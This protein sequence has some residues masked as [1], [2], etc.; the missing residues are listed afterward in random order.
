MN[1]KIYL[2]RDEIQFEL[3]PY[4]NDGN[5]Y[6]RQSAHIWECEAIKFIEKDGYEADV[7]ADYGHDHHKFRIWVCSTETNESDD[8]I[9]LTE[10]EEEDA[11]IVG[12]A[13]D[14]FGMNAAIKFAEED[15]VRANPD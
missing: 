9:E 13:A 1:G 4:P 5:S 15:A 11:I 3:L 8:E 14:E 10:K 6:S 7:N 2:R 12:K